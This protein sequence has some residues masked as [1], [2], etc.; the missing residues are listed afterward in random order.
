VC[1]ELSEDSTRKCWATP[2]GRPYFVMESVPGLPITGYCDRHRL[3]IHERLALFM[4]VCE[5]VQHAH[6]KAVIHRDLKPS[7]V[8]VTDVDQKPV[9][10]TQRPVDRAA[11][12]RSVQ[13]LR[14]TQD[15]ACIQMLVGS[16]NEQIF[17]VLYEC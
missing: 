16:L 2:E 11:V 9:P 1:L 5:G 10:K 7:N 3:T 12:D 4:Q 15:L 14:L 8:L 13:F 6:Q 17:E